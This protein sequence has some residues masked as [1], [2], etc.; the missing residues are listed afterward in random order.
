MWPFCIVGMLPF[1][2]DF[3]RLPEGREQALIQAFV[4]NTAIECFA[5]PIL[6]GL[7]RL[8]KLQGD[9]APLRPSERAQGGEFSPVIADN[10]LWSAMQIDQPGQLPAHA[11]RRSGYQP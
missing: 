6:R 9:T 1:L 3:P 10:K 5:K 11:G 7:A 8:D 4:P 2:G